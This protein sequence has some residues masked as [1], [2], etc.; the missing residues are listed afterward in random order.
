MAS[1]RILRNSTLRVSHF[2]RLNGVVAI[3]QVTANAVGC[4]GYKRWMRPYLMELYHRRLQAGP[5]KERH[6]SEWS[7]WN[8]DAEVYAFGQ[9]LGENFNDDTLRTIFINPS[10]I[11]KE[12]VRR[13]ELGVGDDIIP[14]NLQDNEQLAHEGKKIASRYVKAFLR[15]S[16]P[17]VFEEGISA[18][19]DFLLTE[20]ILAYTGSQIGIKD[21]ILTAEFPVAQDTLAS[22]FL[23]VIGGLAKDQ[24]ITRAERFVNH[25]IL[26]HLVG[27]DISELWYIE[28]PMGLLVSIL[29][30]KGLAEPEPR[31]IRQSASETIMSLY[32]VAVY[33]DKKMLGKAP[34]ETAIIAEEMAARDC[35]K[36]IMKITDDRAPLLLGPNAEGFRLDYDKANRSIYDILLPQ[37]NQRALS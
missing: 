37:I 9:R 10:Y 18:V 14:L 22:T 34:G 12:E 33:S 28:N 3:P 2:L 19:H 30:A 32:W 6:R 20:D 8:Y 24:G 23:A 21:L 15:F 17:Y 31:V 36:R 29:Q 25:F 16:F 5:E 11:E 26:P 1:L 4:R 27:K 13:K 35:L 7:N